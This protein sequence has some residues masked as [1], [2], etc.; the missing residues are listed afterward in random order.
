MTPFWARILLFPWAVLGCWDEGDSRELSKWLW[1][2]RCSM[3]LATACHPAPRNP[4]TN[5]TQESVCSLCG[6]LHIFFPSLQRKKK[7]GYKSQASLP[8]PKQSRDRLRAEPKAAGLP[9]LT[10]GVGRQARWS[11]TSSSP[12]AFGREATAAAAA[13]LA[14]Y[15]AATSGRKT[16][17]KFDV[18]STAG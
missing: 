2:M 7:S 4:A 15:C 8:P 9:P 1:V 3:S 16:Q 5:G 11:Y 10:P 6:Q 12:S 13:A 17:N 18:V 14:T